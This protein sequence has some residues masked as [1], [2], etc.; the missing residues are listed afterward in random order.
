MP[1]STG[2]PSM[3]DARAARLGFSNS[4]LAR[5]SCAKSD[6]EMPDCD[7][8]VVESVPMIFRQ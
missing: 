4:S 2:E 1:R 6:L 3:A 5:F 7:N 8:T